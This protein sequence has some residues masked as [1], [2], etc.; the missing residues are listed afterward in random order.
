MLAGYKGSIQT[1]G[2]QVYDTIGESNGIRL[3]DCLAHAR[4]YFVEAL[5]NDRARSEH[6]LQQIQL[7]YNIEQ[8]C[9]TQQYCDDQRKAIRMEKANPILARLGDWMIEQY[10]MVLPKSPI[11]QA[12]GP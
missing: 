1:D 9:N 12:L 10:P 6:V 4:R 3:I 5:I 8:E 2:Y 7:L 11:G